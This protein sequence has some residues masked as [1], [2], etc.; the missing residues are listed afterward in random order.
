MVGLSSP[1]VTSTV[2]ATALSIIAN[3]LAQIIDARRLASPLYSL[4]DDQKRYLTSPT[5]QKPLAFDVPALFR[6]ILVSALSASL[7]FIWLQWLERTFPA[8]SVPVARHQTISIS[9]RSQSYSDYALRERDGDDASNLLE[10]GQKDMRQTE[11]EKREREGSFA[12]KNMVIKWF[13]DAMTFGALWNASLFLAAMGLLKGNSWAMIRKSITEETV[14]IVLAGYRIWP[15]ASIISFLLVPVEKRIV[16]F[17]FV[18][19][20]WGIYLSL[21]AAKV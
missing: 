10:L 20:L 19:I 3:T 14:P 2:Q 1:V 8:R 16:F 15:L 12:W 11:I 21:A 18:G 6:F 5:L 17:A 4:H 7:N 13:L 9:P